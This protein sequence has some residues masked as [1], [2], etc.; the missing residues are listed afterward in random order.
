MLKTVR[1]AALVVS[2]AVAISGAT[3]DARQA[4]PPKVKVVAVGGFLGFV[5][6]LYELPAGQHDTTPPGPAGGLVGVRRLL[7]PNN[8]RDRNE[9]YENALRLVTG[10][11]MPR[12]AGEHHELPTSASHPFW[13]LLSTIFPSAVAFGTEDL[14]HALSEPDGASHLAQL[15]QQ[16][17]L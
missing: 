14:A 5:D 3:L 13:R 4:P 7:E 16:P 12:Y 1:V 17:P 15:M 8:P 11:N 6:G 2:S 10:N 9:K